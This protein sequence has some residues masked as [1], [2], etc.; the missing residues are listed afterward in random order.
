MTT[1][2]ALVVLGDAGAGH[3][4]RALAIQR[5]VER[6]AADVHLHLIHVDDGWKT[7]PLPAGLKRSR[8]EMRPDDYRSPALAATS[9]LAVALRE[10]R[11]D[12]I[13][14][15][16]HWAPVQQVLA[17]EIGVPAWLLLRSHPP[18]WLRGPA[19]LPF[20]QGRWS[21]IFAIEPLALPVAHE[22]LDP[23]VIANPDEAMPPSALRQRLGL[24][25]SVPLTVRMQ[26]GRPGFIDRL[27]GDE[28]GHVH[29]ADMHAPDAIFP[30]C[31]WLQDADRVLCGGGY[32]SFWEAARMGYADRTRF[33]AF[34]AQIDDQAWR[35]RTFAGV[36]PATNGADALAHRMQQG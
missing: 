2:V 17:T 32:N 22:T 28:V 33:T 30:I 23:V 9:P 25:P 31:T 15:D 1:R 34:P 16:L 6:T 11:P 35:I 10:V 20:D 26:A 27:E 21:R 5:A 29:R 8:V 18:A 24:A 3:R 4:V 12:L 14:C 19:W 7:L 36:R 13:V